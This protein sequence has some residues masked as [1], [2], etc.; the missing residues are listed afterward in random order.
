MKTRRYESPVARTRQTRPN[1]PA[2]AAEMAP[3]PPPKV[4]QVEVGERG[5]G[6]RLDNFL[7]KILKD[8]PRTHL[9]RVIRKGEVRVNGKRAKADTR[10]QA[11]DIVRIPPVR[12][13]AAAPPRK[14]PSAMVQ[15]ILDAIIFEDPRL[16]VVNKPAGVAVHGGSG[17]SFGVIEAL[18][19]ARPHEELEL[20]HRIDRETSGILMVARKAAT[21]RTLHALLREGHVEKRYLA[22]VKGKWEL[23]RKRVDAP[24][25]TDIRVSGERT[26][27]VHETGK[28][29]A[30][31]FKP[32]Q[33]FGRKASLVEVE[34]ETGR[35]HQIR[36]HAAHAGYPLAGD[37][38]YGD[39]AFNATMK[40]LGL[41]RMFLHAHQVSFTWPETGV[42]F[43]V[44]APLPPELAA[45]VD[46]LAEKKRS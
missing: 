19:A 25:R 45:V 26:V 14:A 38:K 1:V 28:E 23:G 43:S 3:Q 34:L 37:E 15:S 13:G 42:E 10:L 18:R 5:E 7:G 39:E 33:F 8:V 4:Q 32:V 27:K 24:L 21:L 36:V 22:L 16:L 31:V 20:V 2:A 17:I 41:T 11:S 35:T 12:V 40:A 44:N 6:Q 9:F 46:T 30:S 29:A